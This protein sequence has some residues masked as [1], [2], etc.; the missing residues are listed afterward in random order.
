[1]ATNHPL[2]QVL[3]RRLF[4]LATIPRLEELVVIAAYRITAS[5]LLNCVV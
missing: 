3:S 1:M 4:A 2:R 5:Y